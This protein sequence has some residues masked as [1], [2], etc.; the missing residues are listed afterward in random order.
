MDEEVEKV[1]DRIEQE[2]LARSPPEEAAAAQTPYL[3][4]RETPAGVRY[5]RSRKRRRAFPHSLG[6]FCTGV[7]VLLTAAGVTA[8]ILLAKEGATLAGWQVVL[9]LLYPLQLALD[10]VAFARL[11]WPAIR[12]QLGDLEVELSADRLRH[13]LRWGPL[14]LDSESILLDRIQRLVVVK[15]PEGKSDTVWELVAEGKDGSATTLVSADDPLNVVP[16]ARDL[17]ARLARQD[18]P[19]GRWPPLVEEDRPAGAG[20]VRPPARPL[21]PGG[22]WTWLAVH[23]AGAAGLWQLGTLP[24]FR[25]PAPP[26]HMAVLVAL[27]ALQG[28][29]LLTNVALVSPKRETAG[30]PP[31]ASSGVTKPRTLE[32]GP[33]QVVVERGPLKEQPTFKALILHRAGEQ[34][35]VLK[36]GPSARLIPLVPFLMGVLFFSIAIAQGQGW[37]ALGGALWLL[38]AS[39]L[40]LGSLHRVELDAGAGRMRTVWLGRR[41]ERPLGQLLAVQRTWSPIREAHY[42]HLVVDDEKKRREN[43]AVYRDG[44]AARAAGEELAAFLGI[45]LLDEVSGERTEKSRL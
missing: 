14:W 19:A 43:L 38:V 40:C 11:T 31:T 2:V 20:T 28:L 26:W 12:W 27:A 9:G 5:V 39:V 35:L 10:L 25:A 33:R 24:W 36:E 3:V 30:G 16:L 23:V 6:N 15:R 45:P 18:G 29:I 8:S 42:L 32:V 17:H 13:G 4:P 41:R 1:F 44:Q 21:L 22:A 7:L 34:L 37:A